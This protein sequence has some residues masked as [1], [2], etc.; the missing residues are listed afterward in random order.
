M[1]IELKNLQPPSKT[2]FLKAAQEKEEKLE[3]KPDSSRQINI[4]PSQ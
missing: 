1:N 2:D 4:F 3:E